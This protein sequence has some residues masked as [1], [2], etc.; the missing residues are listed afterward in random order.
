MTETL[1]IL[2]LPILLGYI[3][4]KIKYLPISISKDIKLFVMRVAVPCRIF[5]AMYEM[6]LGTITQI[7]PLTISFVFMTLFL[8]FSTNIIFR[9]LKDKRVKAIYMI[10]ITFANYGYM[11]WA[12]L[13][14]ALGPEGLTRGIFFNTLWWPVIYAGTFFIGKLTKIESTLDIKK[15]LINIIVPSSVLIL[16]ILFNIFKIPIYSPFLH[17]FTVFGDM[18][19]SLILFS[20]GL[21]ISFTSSFKGIKLAI[22]PVVARPLLGILSGY[23]AITI[24][25]ITDPISRSSIFIESTMPTAVLSVLLGEMLGLDEKLLSSILVLSTLLSLITIPITLMFFK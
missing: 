6:D 13:D 14:S 4:V 10:A 20:V 8:I 22:I 1:L 19:V 3:L 12:V 11:G 16:G 18:T 23:L 2:F 9:N 7:I 21:T 25:N 15:F 5:T 24:I 17:T